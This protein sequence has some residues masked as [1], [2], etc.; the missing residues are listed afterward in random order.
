MP[1]FSTALLMLSLGSEAPASPRP[2]GS[3]TPYQR[4]TEPA[5]QP[6]P[7]PVTSQ[8]SRASPGV[9]GPHILCRGFTCQITAAE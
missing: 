7:S 8:S 2:W 3:R 5:Q 4:K 6:S 1:C 9:W